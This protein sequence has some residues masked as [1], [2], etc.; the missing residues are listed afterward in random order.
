MSSYF[1]FWA[2]TTNKLRHAAADQ[3]LLNPSHRNHGLMGAPA[4]SVVAA[5]SQLLESMGSES[6]NLVKAITCYI[7]T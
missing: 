3:F 7:G 6:Q 2:A 4:L 1:L 5:G